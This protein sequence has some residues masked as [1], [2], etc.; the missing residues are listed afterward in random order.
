MST[1]TGVAADVVDH[2]L[3]G[4]PCHREVKQRDRLAELQRDPAGFTDTANILSF[5]A[6]KKSSRHRAATPLNPP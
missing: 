3:A 1:N 5:A 2:T 4:R 6:A